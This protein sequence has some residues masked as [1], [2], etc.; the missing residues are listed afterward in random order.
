QKRIELDVPVALDAWVRG[1]PRKVLVHK[2]VD[3][4]LAKLSLEVDHVIRNP[5]PPGNGSGVLDGAQRA[6]PGMPWIRL[7]L[8]PDLHGYADNVL[9][10]ANQKPGD[11]AAVDTATHGDHYTGLG[12]GLRVPE[13]GG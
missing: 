8:L 1:P 4:L 10:L 11:D 9:P 6:A 2:T 5:E 7:A 13:A 12:Q 3:H